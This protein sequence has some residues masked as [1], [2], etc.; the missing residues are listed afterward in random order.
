M[1]H[2][3]QHTRRLFAIYRLRAN[4]ATVRLPVGYSGRLF[5]SSMRVLTTVVDLNWV[6]TS[7]LEQ[8]SRSFES[9]HQDAQPGIFL[10]GQTLVVHSGYT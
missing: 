3:P 1:H 10:F 2:G 4:E 9:P 5:C 7:L 6:F 8:T